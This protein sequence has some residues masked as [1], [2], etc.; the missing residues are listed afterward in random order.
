MSC[1]MCGGPASSSEHR[2]KRSDIVK[3]YGRGPYSGGDA[4]VHVVSGS[5]KPV[6]GPRAGTLKYSPS[7]CATCNS[8]R[9]QPFD[10]AYDRL[11]EWVFDNEADVL[12]K[13]FLNFAEVYGATFATDQLDLY[14]YCVKS[15]GC[16]LVDANQ[17]VPPDIVALFDL[18]QF[19]TGL[20]ISFSVNEDVLLMKADNRRGFIG[21][22]GMMAGLDAKDQ[23]RVNWYYMSEHVS[24]FTISHWYMCLPDG[25]LG[26]TW[27]ADSQHVY[28]GSHTPLTA[29]QR[30]EFIEKTGKG[31]LDL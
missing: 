3:A 31:E 14:K 28:L 16:R 5:I 1:W 4:P 13:R 12:R 25:D 9:S 8:T 17:S 29:E 11:I 24:W 22:T 26:S 20:R 7:L 10:V 21:K 23:T 15:F 18:T 27:V 30:A 6:R 19:Q 2:L